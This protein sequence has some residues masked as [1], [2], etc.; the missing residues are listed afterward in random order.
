MPID[1]NVGEAVATYPSL[2]MNR[3]GVAYL[4][5][6]VLA[7]N[8]AADPNAPPGYFA[9]DTRI[10][11]YNGS[12]WSVLGVPA[13]RNQAAPV[14]TPTAGNSPKVG[15]DV[16]GNG[17]VAFHEPDDDFVDR[18]WARRLF[19][20]SLGIPLLVSPQEYGGRPL[21]GAADA[22]T[23]DVRGFGTGAIAFRQQPGPNSALTGPRLFVNTIPEAF[24]DDAGRFLGPRLSDGAGSGSLGSSLSP[25]DVGVTPDGAFRTTFGVGAPPASR[26]AGRRGSTR[27]SRWGTTAVWAMRTRSWRWLRP[28]RGWP[29]GG[30]AGR[31]SAC[32]SSAWTASRS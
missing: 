27:H 30:L 14:S 29:P 15:I 10:A 13:D 23:L 26:P 1:L 9:A 18:V 31:W 32:T 28:R 24:R 19:G 6:R 2:A 5:Y 3:G 8:G 11:R 16:T 21:R 4:V 25:P 17:I 7:G 12:L 22:F 20:S